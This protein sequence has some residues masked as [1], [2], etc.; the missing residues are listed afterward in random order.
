MT[1]TAYEDPNRLISPSGGSS[2]TACDIDHA[3]IRRRR[4]FI[5]AVVDDDQ[6]ILDSIENLPESAGH[7][8]RL[9]ASAAAL[10]E[11]GTLA[12]LDCL[13]PDIDLPEIDGFELLRRVHAGRPELPVIFI[14]GHPEMLD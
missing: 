4:A 6:T 1:T 8:A 12:E 3:M 7:V 10:L 11:S 2:V 14:A 13:I 9:F 5:V